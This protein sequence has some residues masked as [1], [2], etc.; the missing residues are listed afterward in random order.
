VPT[1]GLAA[2][3][4]NAGIKWYV[5]G[6]LAVLMLPWI[7]VIYIGAAL[8]QLRTADVRYPGVRRA[9]TSLAIFGAVAGIYIL[10]TLISAAAR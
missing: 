7:A 10:S 4:I 5:I 8:F 9:R 6:T 2:A 1:G 3:A